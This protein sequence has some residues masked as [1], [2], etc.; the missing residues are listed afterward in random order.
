MV[1]KSQTTTVWMVLKPRK[2]W[3]KLPT[4]LNWWVY[5]SSEP[6]R[7][8]NLFHSNSRLGPPIKNSHGWTSHPPSCVSVGLR[9][10]GFYVSLISSSWR[11]G[12]GYPQGTIDLGTC[13]PN[14]WTIDLPTHWVG[15]RRCTEGSI[16][17]LGRSL[18]TS[19]RKPAATWRRERMEGTW[20]APEVL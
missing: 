9:V 2:L 12:W 18:R 5:R 15:P 16:Q 4:S 11:V 7:V 13:L 14:R 1:Q 10:I 17:I 19:T 20:R 6:S 8:S 3:D